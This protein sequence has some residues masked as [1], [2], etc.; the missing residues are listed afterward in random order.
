MNME[1]T[2]TSQLSGSVPALHFLNANNARSTTTTPAAVEGAI[3]AAV[4]SFVSRWQSSGASERA[5]Y[6]LF[7]TR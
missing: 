5:N 1:A 7:L 4:P 2:Q 6:A 3:D